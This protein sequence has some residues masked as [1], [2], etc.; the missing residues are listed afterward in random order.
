MDIIAVVSICVYNYY[1]VSDLTLTINKFK[2]GGGGKS[3]GTHPCTYS[4]PKCSPALVYNQL[5]DKTFLTYKSFKRLLGGC[6][7]IAAGSSMSS[8]G[9]AMKL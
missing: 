8:I 4:L 2:G 5:V 6:P 1:D 3:M 7:A 9:G